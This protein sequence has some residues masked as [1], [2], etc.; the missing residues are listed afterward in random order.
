MDVPERL[1]RRVPLIARVGDAPVAALA[2][3]LWRV[4]SGARQFTLSDAADDGVRAN[5]IGVYLGY[6]F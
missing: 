6:R 2:L 5:S 4:G 1:V 3:E